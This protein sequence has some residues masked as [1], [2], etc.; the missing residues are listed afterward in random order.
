MSTPNLMPCPFCGHEAEYFPPSAGTKRGLI[1]VRCTHCGAQSASLLSSGD[2]S[3]KD[4]DAAALWNRRNYALRCKTEAQS[5][6]LDDR[7]KDALSLN[8][9]LGRLEGLACGCEGAMQTGLL[10]TCEMLAEIIERA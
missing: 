6:E 2:Y 8:Y 5:A 7:T 4:A 9:V 10:D 1:A 3:F